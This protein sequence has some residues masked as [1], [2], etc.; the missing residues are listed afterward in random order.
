MEEKQDKHYIV[1]DPETGE[2]VDRIYGGDRIVRK[3]QIEFY[4]KNE[5]EIEKDRVYN[6]GQSDKFTMLSQNAA[7]ELSK[8]KIT[9]SE[10]QIMFLMMANTN[11]KSGLI[12][13]GNNHNIDENWI[14]EQLNINIITV[15]RCIKKFNDKGIIYKGEISFKIQYFFNPYIQ[16]KGS[17]INKTLYEMFKNTPWALLSKKDK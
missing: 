13:K 4:S 16:Y 9:G 5:K 14:A 11:Y 15:E 2:I 7:K 12:T 17:W 10:Y 1:A 6:F 3:K 8:M